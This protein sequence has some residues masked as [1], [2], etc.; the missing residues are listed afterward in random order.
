[1]ERK[2][3]LD[4]K[5]RILMGQKECYHCLSKKS[6]MGI[7]LFYVK[8]FLFQEICIAANPLE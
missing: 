2:K 7:E 5:I 8:T 4:R 3:I 1:M 6:Y